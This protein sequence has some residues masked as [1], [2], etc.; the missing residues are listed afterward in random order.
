MNYA[1]AKE[2]ARILRPAYRPCPGFELGCNGIARW[3]PKEGHVPRGFVGALSS[4]EEVQV[5]IVV[6]EPGDPLP[7]EAYKPKRNPLDQTARHTYNL[8]TGGNAQFHQNLRY[9]LGLIFPK[10]P[11]DQQLRKAWVTEAYLCSAPSEGGYV[12]AEAE[13]ECTERYLAKQLD[14]FGDIPVIALGGKAH[15]RTRRVM[16]HPQN[17]I[18]AYA[19]APPGS[20]RKAALPSW[21]AAAKRARRMIA[22]RSR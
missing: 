20:N 11:M 14:L 1:P 10:L 4:I 7:G 5:A 9:L 6:A 19:V 8:L 22:K 2:L 13:K 18:E 15:K 12:R 21:Q 16:R 17:L 3:I